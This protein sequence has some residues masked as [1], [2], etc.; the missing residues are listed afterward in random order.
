MMATIIIVEGRCWRMLQTQHS[1]WVKPWFVSIYFR[2]VIYTT[3]A[4]Y[5]CSL[6]TPVCICLMY[7]WIHRIKTL[8]KKTQKKTNWFCI[9]SHW[10][11]I[12]KVRFAVT[13]IQTG[14]ITRN[15]SMNNALLTQ[16]TART[17]LCAYIHT[18]IVCFIVI[19]YLCIVLS[20]KCVYTVII[21][22]CGW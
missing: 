15:F 3:L 19:V 9:L 1:L 20:M 5:N 21:V 13:S 11:L 6:P 8:T 7:I 10:S 16:Y 18:H 12:K 22:M 2:L 14:T 4:Q 17:T